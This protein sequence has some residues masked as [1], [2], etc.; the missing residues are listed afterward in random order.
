[1]DEEMKI[2]WGVRDWVWGPGGLYSA[3]AVVDTEVNND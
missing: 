3:G 2:K 1:M